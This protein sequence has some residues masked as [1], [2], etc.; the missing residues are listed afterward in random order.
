MPDNNGKHLLEVSNLSIAFGKATPDQAV[1]RRVSFTLKEGETLGI[2]GES[3]SGK[4]LSALALMGLLPQQANILEGS[5]LLHSGEAEP[6]DLIRLEH[7]EM[8]KLRGH[9]ITMIFQEPMSSLNPVMRCGKQVIEVMRQHLQLTG[10]EARKRCIGLF[11]EVQL[12]R[13]EGI[14]RSYPHQR[15]GGQK[16]RVMIAMAMACNPRLIIADEPTTAL[17]VTVQ[18]AILGLL[19]ELARKHNTA[20]IFITHDLGVVRSIADNVLVMKNG[21]V[22]EQGPVQNVFNTP[23]HPYTQGLMACRPGLGHR[24]ERLL[25]VQDF[26]AARESGKE[27]F[28]REIGSDERRQRL[29]TLYSQDPILKVSG[30]QTWFPSSLSLLGKVKS[31]VKAVDD[32]GLEVYPG[33]TLGLVGESGSGKTTLGRSILRLQPMRGGRIV[34]LGRPLS[35]LEGKALRDERKGLQ[36]IFQ[37]PYSSLNPR[38]SA[39]EAIMEPMKVHRL[40]GSDQER[41]QKA[42]A[43]M[44]KVGLEVRQFNRYPHE[45]SGGQRQRIGIAR[46]LALEPSFIVCDESV[47]AL[48]VSV[49]AQVLNL[50]NALK[51][52]F[53]LTYIF[54]SH[55]LSVVR[56]MSDRIV[57]L[58]DGKVVES[59]DA[60]E[61]ILN[62][63]E[64]YT[65]ALIEAIPH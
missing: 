63:K 12:P 1:V 64:D 40:H 55:D 46:A 56:Y 16:Q 4:T 65:R 24:P 23:C 27:V 3:G 21:E 47:S 2:V 54:I 31:W 19:K 35:Q 6:R 32:V 8:R 48:D 38:I 15:S 49:Q 51:K 58:R 17:D 30:L 10:K 34:Y 43:L 62:P 20:I 22:V 44:E 18:K 33:E 11:R 37:D 13:P 42:L 9:D 7:R 59:G 61:L 60:D 50:L 53:G 36:I 45:F 25:T 14:Y 5:A 52:E 28:V 41:R 26:L 57:V 29:Q 39:G